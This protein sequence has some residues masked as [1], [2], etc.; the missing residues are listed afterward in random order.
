MVREKFTDEFTP[1]DDNAPQ[2][3]AARVETLMTSRNAALFDMVMT[4]GSVWQ[5]VA[6][7]N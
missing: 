4:H 7:L 6:C 1:Q 3:E 2:H 5:V